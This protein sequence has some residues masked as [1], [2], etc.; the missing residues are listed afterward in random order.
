MLRLK[1]FAALRPRAELAAEIAAVPYD[2]VNTEEARALAQGKPHSLLHVSRSEIDLPPSTDPYAPEVYR[3]AAD[4]FSALT[5]QA[6]VREDAPSIYLYRQEMVLLGKQVSQLGIV[7]CCHVQDYERDVI[8]RHEKTRRDKEDDRTRHLLA[9][10]ANAEPVFLMFRD[11]PGLRTLLERDA[12]GTP[13]YDFQAPDGVRHSV[14]RASSA[15]AYVSE[16]A[17]ID[18]AYVADGHHRIASA[19]RGAAEL[20]KGDDEHNWF[21]SVLFPASQLTILPYHR[22]L[23]DLNGMTPEALLG[24]LRE[25]ASVTPVAAP[26][27]KQPGSFALYLAGRWYLVALPASSIDE[28]S[29]IRSLDYTLLYDHILKPIFGIGDIRTDKRIDF[30]GGIRGTKELE[31]RVDSGDGA[32]AFAMRAT[33]I[34]HLFRVSDAG[35]IMPPKSTWFEPKLRSG[36]LIHTFD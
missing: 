18:A 19:A 16:F 4:N 17:A 6:F 7:G 12:V 33:S 13:L 9:L 22:V 31:R 23:F 25:V 36:L 27:P 34:E 11:R 28:S 5:K 10:R 14:W 35:E 1:P 15:Q 3:R 21:M 32:A 8:K 20:G 26:E 30:V 29:A 2:V 24:R